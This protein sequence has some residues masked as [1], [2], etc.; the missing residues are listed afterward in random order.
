M[1]E[2]EKSANSRCVE[3]R[4]SCE[5]PLEGPRRGDFADV[6]P[7]DLHE[8]GETI[9][10]GHQLC[11][12]EWAS[13]QCVEE[14]SGL[15][16]V[17]MAEPGS[18]HGTHIQNPAGFEDT[19]EGLCNLD[20]DNIAE[21]LDE[22]GPV[23]K[24]EQI[25]VEMSEQH[26]D[27]QTHHIRPQCFHNELHDPSLRSLHMNTQYTILD[28]ITYKTENEP[29]SIKDENT[30]IELDISQL[31]QYREDLGQQPDQRIPLQEFMKPCSV[32]VERLSLQHTHKSVHVC[33][34]LAV[35]NNTTEFTRDSE[36]CNYCAQC[37]KSFLGSRHLKIHQRIHT[38]ERPFY[39]TECG[40]SFSRPDILKSHQKIHTG[41]RPFTCDQCG[42]SFTGSG[43]LNVHYRIHTGEKPFKCIQCGKSFIRSSTL[44][45][46]VRIHTGEKP[47]SC[48]QCGKSFVQAAHLN[49]HQRIHTGEKPHSCD[50][51]GKG[52]TRS[53]HL[54]LHYRIHTGE[55]PYNCSKCG[56]NFFSSTKL[57]SHLLTHTKEKPYSCAQ[58]GKR[59]RQAWGLKTHQ[60]IHI[61][62]KDED[63]TAVLSVENVS[64]I[65]STL[66]H[67]C[68][69]TQ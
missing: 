2:K 38:G 39:C 43:Y 11:K 22:I 3:S 53:H 60:R 13:S 67:T 46:H 37:G 23:I 55:K 5:A 68:I 27:L 59:F 4:V 1:E 48:G 52:F 56:K 6:G 10:T 57:N 51:C 33:S 34:P 65:Q 15:E 35:N 66:N 61:A 69:P 28:C 29:Q 9:P 7:S 30:G 44:T 62:E 49:S 20:P 12:E 16:P 17:H 47:Y 64:F 40:K 45:S 21:S 41:E 58:C 32:R 26:T 24:L 63:L 31:E 54:K 25:E 42:K 14:L 8:G 50:Q 18:E 19:S 36:G